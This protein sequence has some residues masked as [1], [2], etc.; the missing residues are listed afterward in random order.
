MPKIGEPHPIAPE[1]GGATGPGKQELPRL[2]PGRI[3]YINHE[4]RYFLVEAP[5]GDGAVI[6]ECFKF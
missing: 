1:A 6:R 5:I 2:L 3:T 4:H